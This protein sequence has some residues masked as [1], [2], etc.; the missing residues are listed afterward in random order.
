[1]PLVAG[2]TPRNRGWAGLRDAGVAGS[3]A[4]TKGDSLLLTGV[5]TWGASRSLAIMFSTITDLNYCGLSGASKARRGDGM[6]TQFKGYAAF[7][8]ISR[9]VRAGNYKKTLQ[10][11]ESMSAARSI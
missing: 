2:F 7:H 9:A 1:M 6:N 8:C 5:R 11:V 3:E 10:N 4:P